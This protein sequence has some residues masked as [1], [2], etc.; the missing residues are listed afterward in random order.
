MAL[1][2]CP[3]CGKEVSDKAGKCPNCGYDLRKYKIKNKIQKIPI[4]KLSTKKLVSI[5]I[6]IASALVL[7]VFIFSN[8]KVHVKNIEFE[9]FKL[10]GSSKSFTYYDGYLVSEEKSPFVAL[11]GDY[12][13]ES[14]YPEMVYMDDGKGILDILVNND[15]DD[16]DP[17]LEA[18]PVGYVNCKKIKSSQLKEIDCDTRDYMDFSYDSSTS[19]DGIIKIRMNKKYTGILLVDVYNDETDE[20]RHD[21]PIEI[22]NGAGG[23]EFYISDLPYKCRDVKITVN[24]KAFIKAQKVKRNDYE[25]TKKMT[26]EEDEDGCGYDGKEIRCFDGFKNGYIIYSEE[27]LSGGA[28]SQR[29]KKEIET[30]YLYDEECKINTY[31]YDSDDPYMKEPDYAIDILGYIKITELK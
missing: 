15:N 6:L 11:I 23:D 14:G 12:R 25:Y 24:P 1:T 29:G 20:V 27:L 26:Y 2:N 5:G 9:K 21:Y 7:S 17:A 13:D 8:R 3:E 22:I 28:E 18:K 30:T 19:C 31:T 4:K 10:T 16:I